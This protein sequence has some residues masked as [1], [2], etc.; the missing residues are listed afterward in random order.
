[1]ICHPVNYV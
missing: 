1:M